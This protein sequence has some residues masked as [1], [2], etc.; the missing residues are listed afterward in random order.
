MDEPTVPA[1]W[2]MDDP[3]IPSSWDRDEPNLPTS[4]DRDVPILQLKCPVDVYTGPEVERE[5]TLLHNTT[6]L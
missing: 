4:W 2:N 1:S 3:T 6:T 5:T